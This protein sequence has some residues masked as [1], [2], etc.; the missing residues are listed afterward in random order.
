MSDRLVQAVQK[1][2]IDEVR[3]ALREGAD[4]RHRDVS[5]S[6]PPFLHVAI[7]GGHTDVAKLLLKHGV[8]PSLQDATGKPPLTLAAEMGNAEATQ[9]LL[10]AGASPAYCERYGRFSALHIAA[11]KGYLDV[12]QLLLANGANPVS[13]ASSGKVLDGATCTPLHIAAWYGHVEIVK[14]LL[15]IGVDADVTVSHDAW[16]PCHAASQNGQWPVVRVLCDEGADADA[17]GRAGRRPLQIAAAAGHLTAAEVLA[18]NGADVN[19]T[20]ENGDTPLHAAAKSGRAKMCQRLLELG[21]DPTLRNKAGKTPAQ[22]VPAKRCPALAEALTRAEGATAPQEIPETDP[23]AT[24]AKRRRSHAT[25]PPVPAEPD[26]EQPSPPATAAQHDAELLLDAVGAGDLPRLRRLLAEGIAPDCCGSDERTPLIRAAQQNHVELIGLLL[27]AGA[28]PD[29]RY[30]LRRR[31]T[32]L[33]VA[34]AWGNVDAVMAFMEA[35]ID[36]NDGTCGQPLVEAARGGNAAVVRLL[37]T[38]GAAPDKP[39]AEGL[40]PLH[41]A[42]M[43]YDCEMATVLLGSGASVQARTPQLATPL[44]AAALQD[45]SAIVEVLATSGSNLNACACG[46]DAGIL[47]QFEAGERLGAT[48]GLPERRVPNYPACM[49]LNQDKWQQYSIGFS[50]LHYAAAGGSVDAIHRLCEL[51]ADI[52]AG[53][54]PDQDATQHYTLDELGELCVGCRYPTHRA[55]N[56]LWIDPDEPFCSL[57]QCVEYHDGPVL[58]TPLHLAVAGGHLDAVAALLEH[59]ADIGARSHPS[60]SLR[61]WRDCGC[62]VSSPL[63]WVVKF[64]QN[65]IAAYLLE[66]GAPP[67]AVGSDEWDTWPAKPLQAAIT[68]GDVNMALLL[69]QYGADPSRWF[70]REYVFGENDDGGF[71]SCTDDYGILSPLHWAAI[72]GEEHLARMLLEHG[73]DVNVT[74]DD[75]GPTP[76]DCA[77][78]R[79]QHEMATLLRE[80]GGVTSEYDGD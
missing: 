15:S 70:E 51:G 75:W 42:A 30:G 72:K 24:R 56:S 48:M 43:Q 36:P 25:A 50:P 39:D 20:A 71:A 53:T 58:P 76:L 78:W 6:S 73:A 77:L 64:R 26:S 79:K 65:Q 23:D 7:S 49:T 12:L 61:P 19:G 35:G 16:T 9:A 40:V 54:R 62:P 32:A 74:A 5:Y 57:S 2:D 14:L 37:L 4:P 41:Y 28:R 45:R 10:E 29:Y 18:E 13:E 21:A 31:R 60:R 22:R 34:A 59:G 55:C 67:N 68:V 1:G 27:S 11:E 44:H 47:W 33:D 3:Q 8:S 46:L 17:P 63:H 66:Q 52:E 69:L 80:N 38:Y